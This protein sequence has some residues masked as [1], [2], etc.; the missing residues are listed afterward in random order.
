MQLQLKKD[1]RWSVI[2]GQAEVYDEREDNGIL[3]NITSENYRER[4]EILSFQLS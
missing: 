2:Q 1:S 4:P 3:Y